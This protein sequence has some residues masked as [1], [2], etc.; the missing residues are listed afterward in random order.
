MTRSL[1]PG[2]FAAA[3]LLLPACGPKPKP[4]PPAPKPAPPQAAAASA[5]LQAIYEKNT[6][7]VTL[8]EFEQIR[9]G[10]TDEQVISI[11]GA[12]PSSRSSR[13]NPADEAGFTRPSATIILRW[14]NPDRSWCELEMRDKKVELKR[15]QDLKPMKSYL[16][17]KFNLPR[18]AP[19]IAPK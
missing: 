1:F 14:D 19:E 5:D 12:G 18:S 10:M 7:Q 9:N 16:G 15:H 17:S 8:D 6:I 11:I 3:L 2:L 4:Q 13:Y